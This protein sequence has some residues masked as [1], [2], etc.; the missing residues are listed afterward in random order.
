MSKP[1]KKGPGRPPKHPPAPSVEKLGVIDVAAVDYHVLELSYDNPQDFKSIFNYFKS[2]KAEEI[3]VV[4]DKQ[5]MKIYARDHS[6]TST[7]IVVIDGA[8]MNTY[9][10]KEESLTFGLNRARVEKLFASIDKDF[11]TIEL[12]M[13]R[14][15]RDRMEILLK[16]STISKDCRYDV[17]LTNY[18]LDHERYSCADMLS[19]ETAKTFRL[20]FRL[21]SKD[22]KKTVTDISN[23]STSMTI[24]KFGTKPL[25]ITYT[26]ENKLQYAESYR[27][28]D[29]IFLVHDLKVNESFV[30]TLD[31]IS[32]AKSITSCASVS[33]TKIS[34]RRGNILFIS[35][36]GN[37]ITIYTNLQ[38]T[39][40]RPPAE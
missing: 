38:T 6:N 25:Q 30:C 14:H 21:S 5:G 13:N 19:E 15:E 22:F 33:E 27:D 24:E 40:I 8:N 36:L 4:C 11:Y 17:F 26:K 7:T 23:Y 32:V 2:I 3:H 10:C 16:N 35:P 12:S 9:F 34:C 39:A 28:P 31:D 18:P 37:N 1:E 20:S 29:K